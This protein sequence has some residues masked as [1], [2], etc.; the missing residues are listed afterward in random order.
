MKV[1]GMGSTGRSH[2]IGVF[3]RYLVKLKG[4]SRYGD[5][6]KIQLNDAEVEGVNYIRVYRDK[7]QL[8][9]F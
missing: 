1:N 3:G 9:S 8:W 7:S 5:D 2:G 6:I 4:E